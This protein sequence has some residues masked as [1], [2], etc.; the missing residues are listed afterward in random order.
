[1][2]HA[3]LIIQNLEFNGVLL[4]YSHDKKIEDNRMR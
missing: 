4:T 3:S 1:M 2:L